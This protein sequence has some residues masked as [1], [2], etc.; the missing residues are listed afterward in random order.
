MDR[1]AEIWLLAGYPFHLPLLPAHKFDHAPITDW[2]FVV[3]N[4]LQARNE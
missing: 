2:S 4:N 1:H 3:I